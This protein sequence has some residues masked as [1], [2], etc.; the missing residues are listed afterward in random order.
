MIDS[1]K[2]KHAD[3]TLL[4]EQ[5]NQPST[6]QMRPIAKNRFKLLIILSALIILYNE[7]FVY[8]LAYLN[9][10]SVHKSSLFYHKNGTQIHDLNERPVRLILV[11]DP[12]LIGENDEPWFIGWL[13]RWDAD[14]YLRSCFV[15]ANSY[16][17][18]DATIFLGDL[19]DEGLKASDDQMERY[20]NR[21]ESIFHSHKMSHDYG[22]KQIYISGDNDVGGEYM[23]DRNNRLVRRFE[24]YFGPNVELFEFNSYIKFLKLDVDYTASFYAGNKR[25][26]VRSLVEKSRQQDNEMGQKDKLTIILNHISLVRKNPQELDNLNKDTG[27]SLIIKG[28]NHLFEI[29]KFN[30]VKNRI[31]EYITPLKDKTNNFYMLSLDTEKT[32]KGVEFVYELSIPTCSYRMGVPNMGYGLL[33]LMPNGQAYVSILWLPSRYKSI[34]F[35]LVYLGCIACYFLFNLCI[36]KNLKKINLIFSNKI[37]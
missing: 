36:K 37:A 3:T 22:I 32:K 24:K 8:W 25:K 4:E 2:F 15:L 35:Y 23:G 19:F 16:T 31:E 30:Y 17:K 11:A 12:Q 27:S 29:I 9:W 20:F 6:F 13:A 10:P 18:P 34:K 1:N 33:T 26:Y 14:R 7:V 28:D 21:F 5:R